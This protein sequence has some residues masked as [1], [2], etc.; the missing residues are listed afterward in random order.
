MMPRTAKW[1]DAHERLGW[2]MAAGV[3]AFIVA[4]WLAGLVLHG[5]GPAPLAAASGVDLL[6]PDAA[7]PVA[8]AMISFDERED[9]M[10]GARSEARG[11]LGVLD[12]A[13]DGF[14]ISM[15]K[16]LD[17]ARVAASLDRSKPYRVSQWNNGQ[18]LLEDPSTGAQIELS[19]FGKTNAAAFAALI[20]RAR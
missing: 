6:R 15:F 7:R 18:V 2:L 10:M 20:E 14:I 9:R 8:Q 13:R 17:R 19:A 11:D 1:N 16:S 3:F 12:S 5:A 4:I